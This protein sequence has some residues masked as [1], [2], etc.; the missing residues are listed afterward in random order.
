MLLQKMN[1]NEV[2]D[3]DVEYNENGPPEHLWASIAP[4]SE[5]CRLNTLQENEETLT[6]LNQNDIND[7][8][9]LM[10]NVS[11]SSCILQRQC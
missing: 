7:T 1:Y 9:A 3:N 11:S 10:T 4:N 2:P 8:T 6:D 5:E